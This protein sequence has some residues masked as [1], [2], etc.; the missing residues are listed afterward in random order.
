[1]TSALLVL[2]CI[3]AKDFSA[4]VGSA[5]Q[6]LITAV[7]IPG[8]IILGSPELEGRMKAL[9]GSTSGRRQACAGGGSL[10]GGMWVLSC[11]FSL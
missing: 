10:E 11:R 3:E 1:M 5:Q 2:S 4:E 8:T 7:D 9:L 6:V